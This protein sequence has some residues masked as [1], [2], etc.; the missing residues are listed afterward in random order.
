MADIDSTT[1]DFSFSELTS[2][3]DVYEEEPRA[4]AIK[5]AATGG[6]GGKGGVCAKGKVVVT[7][8]KLNNNVIS[9]LTE[10]PTI[11]P[12]ILVDWSQ[13]VF[14]DLSF[15]CLNAIPKELECL[16]QLGILYLHGNNIGALTEVCFYFFRLADVAW[17]YHRRFFMV[18]V[19]WLSQNEA[20]LPAKELRQVEAKKLRQVDKI[21]K[22]MTNLKSFSLHGSYLERIE[23]YRQHV[24]AAIPSLRKFDFVAVTSADRERAA[25]W[26]AM[27][28]P[29]RTKAPA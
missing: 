26:K 10:L 6:K 24:V 21:G 15:N 8:L 4:G 1:L 29:R 12:D 28:S 20:M 27:H 22:L 17:W 23:G 25:R 14:L 7:T 9:D 19:Y 2:L 13:L 5:A 18:V 3:P 11:L 16:P